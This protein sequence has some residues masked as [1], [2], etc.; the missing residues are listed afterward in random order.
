MDARW[1]A[2]FRLPLKEPGVT[3]TQLRRIQRRHTLYCLK[4]SLAFKRQHRSVLPAAV[5][6]SDLELFRHKLY[7]P[8]GTADEGPYGDP[9]QIRQL[10]QERPVQLPPVWW[11]TQALGDQLVCQQWPLHQGAFV[12]CGDAPQ[13]CYNG[14]FGEQ[15]TWSGP[16][17]SLEAPSCSRKL[18][19]DAQQESGRRADLLAECPKPQVPQPAE[20]CPAPRKAS[21]AIKP[22]KPGED[23]GSD[24]EESDSFSNT[25][26]A[27]DGRFATGHGLYW[28]K[29]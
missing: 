22:V 12:P 6:A 18:M 29:L 25:S 7:R 4:A 26:A 9:G 5:A 10:Y 3:R 16:W 15:L 20:S 2:T 28:Q 24:S 11:P 1:Q 23:G 14:D 8:H 13:Y 17:T 27:P 19:P 21:V